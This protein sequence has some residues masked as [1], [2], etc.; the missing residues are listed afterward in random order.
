MNT[1]I[2]E[3]LNADSTIEDVVAKMN[4]LIAS[5]NALGNRKPREYG[6]K[7]QTP[8][9]EELAWRIMYGDLKDKKVKDIAEE[10]ELSRGQVYSVRGNYTFT[11]VKPDSFEIDED[12]HI[13]PEELDDALAD[14]FTAQSA[15]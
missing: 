13:T 4:E 3:L 6:P 5:H 7:S 8:M 2:I 12:D 11:Y 1:Q 15:E 9:N 10:F 14:A